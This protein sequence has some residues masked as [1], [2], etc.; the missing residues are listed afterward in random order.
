LAS[1]CARSTYRQDARFVALLSRGGF[2][3]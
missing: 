1:K 3:Q 2:S